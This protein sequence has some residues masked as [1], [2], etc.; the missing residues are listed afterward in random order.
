MQ[1]KHIQAGFVGPHEVEIYDK[2]GLY[3]LGQIPVWLDPKDPR[4]AKEQLNANYQ[5]GGGWNSFPGF[6]W[7]D[8]G[9]EIVYAPKGVWSQQLVDEGEADPPMSP[10]AKLNFRD[11]ETILVYPHEWISIVQPDR[12]FEI[13]RMD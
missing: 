4:P 9:D 7:T 1:H 5:H 2:E 3:W 8:N 11:K 6:K 10:R 12:S 13:C